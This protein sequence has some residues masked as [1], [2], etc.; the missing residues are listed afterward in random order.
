[1]ATD[2]GSAPRVSLARLVMLALVLL[3]GL[4]LFF[5]LARRTP[6]MIHPDVEATP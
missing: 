6:V 3:T 1:M 4:V 2:P 5:A